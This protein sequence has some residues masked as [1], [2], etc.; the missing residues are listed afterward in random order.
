MN[1]S[2]NFIK[3]SK[4]L[5]D[6]GVTFLKRTKMHVLGLPHYILIT[7]PITLKIGFFEIKIRWGGG[8][9]YKT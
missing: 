7:E 2:Y 6:Y 9:R 4:K 8:G 1:N 5:G 3:A